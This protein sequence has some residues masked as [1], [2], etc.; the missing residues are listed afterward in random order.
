MKKITVE[1][2]QNLKHMDQKVEVTFIKMVEAFSDEDGNDTCRVEL[3]L[4]GTQKFFVDI[5]NYDTWVQVTGD[6]HFYH[7]GSIDAACNENCISS[8]SMHGDATDAPQDTWKFLNDFDESY[9]FVQAFEDAVHEAMGSYYKIVGIAE[10]LATL[11]KPTVKGYNVNGGYW[12][13]EH[14]YQMDQGAS[15]EDAKIATYEAM[16]RQVAKYVSQGRRRKKD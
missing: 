14:H 7:L 3:L 11:D 6:V 4:N 8:M 12:W 15:Y 2:Y 10:F 9:Y 13:A 5:D 16:K 1:D